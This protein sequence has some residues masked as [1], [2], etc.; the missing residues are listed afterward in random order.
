MV[1]IGDED[2]NF[3]LSLEKSVIPGRDLFNGNAVFLKHRYGQFI[4][5]VF[6][7]FHFQP[8]GIG[9]IRQ[10]CCS[11]RKWKRQW[12]Y[13]GTAFTYHIARCH[14]LKNGFIKPHGYLRLTLYPIALYLP[15][16]KTAPLKK[17]FSRPT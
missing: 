1:R 5:S 11:F 16:W 15:G 2:R 3:S 13:N 4:Y 7:N 14:P 12:Y 6:G 9:Q 10:N 17:R 8:T